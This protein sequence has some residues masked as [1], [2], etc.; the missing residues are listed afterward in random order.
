MLYNSLV[1]LICLLFGL[2]NAEVLAQESPASAPPL[3]SKLGLIAEE[4]S[5]LAEHPVVD[6][7]IIQNL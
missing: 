3:L 5:W 2:F 6:F 7:F 1:L 4:L